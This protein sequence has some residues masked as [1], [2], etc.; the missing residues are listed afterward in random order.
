[1][2]R[3]SPRKPKGISGRSIA[4]IVFLTICAAFF[5][6]PLY[7]IVTT[8]FKTMAQVREGAIFSLP[9]PFTFDAWWSAWDNACSGITCSGLKVGFFNSLAILFP[10]LALSIAL[11]SVTGYALALWNVKWAGTFL[12]ILF[13]CASCRSRSS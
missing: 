1:M 11:S 2:R 9:S 4:I 8:S 5:C 7:I 13:I 3:C 12:F 10:S 6:V